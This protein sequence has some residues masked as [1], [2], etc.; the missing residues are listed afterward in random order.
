MPAT[1]WPWNVSRETFWVV[2]LG[3][4]GGGRFFAENGPTDAAHLVAMEC[5]T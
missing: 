2:S 1:W 3:D 4:L 5:F